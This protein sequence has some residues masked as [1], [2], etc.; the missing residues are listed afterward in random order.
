[1]YDSSKSRK[2]TMW[3]W[4]D[5]EEGCKGRMC[6]RGNGGHTMQDAGSETQ[7]PKNDGTL[8]LCFKNRHGFVKC[9]DCI[10]SGE[11]Q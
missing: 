7:T 3:K 10:C 4:K 5:L 11:L 6:P 2:E 8:L 1:M 9:V